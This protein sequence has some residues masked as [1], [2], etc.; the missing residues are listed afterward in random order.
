MRLG[1]VALLLS[2]GCAACDTKDTCGGSTL[3]PNDQVCDQATRTCVDRVR[4]LAVPADL[5]VIV[6]LSAAAPDLSGSD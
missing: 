2:L 6:D 4:D 1:M 3:C 5:R